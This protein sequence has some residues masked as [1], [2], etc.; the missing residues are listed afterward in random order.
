MWVPIAGF[1]TVSSAVCDRD[2]G[3]RHVERREPVPGISLGHGTR[4]PNRMTGDVHLGCWPKGQQRDEESSEDIRNTM[5][6]TTDSPTRDISWTE[7]SPHD[8]VVVGAGPAGSMAARAA[9]EGGASVLLIEEDWEIG[10]PLVCAE[11]VGKETL[12]QFVDVDPKWVAS[13]VEGAIFVSPSGRRVRVNYPDAGY[14]LERKVF[15]RDLAA[16]A[17]AAGARV[18][19]G[20]EAVGVSPGEN[21]LHRVEVRRGDEKGTIEA[22][23][24]IGADGF[25]SR[26]GRWAGLDTR[27]K[28]GEIHS[29]VQYLVA[30][31][32]VEEHY[33]EF[34]AGREIAPGGYAWVF[35][36]GRG[37]A[38]VGVGISPVTA[39]QSAL[40]Y[41]ERFLD[42]RFPGAMRLERMVGGVPAKPQERLVGNGLLLVGD[43]ARVADPISGA[44]IINALASGT[45]AGQIAA[46]ALR[47]G[48]V[49]GRRLAAYQDEWERT[50]G[51]DIRF[52]AR[53]RDVFLKL[54]DADFEAILDV[55]SKLFAKGDVRSIDPYQ[56][57][58]AIITSSPR[59][60]KIARHLLQ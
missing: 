37:T 8:C 29:C 1:A 41:L 55:G 11:G 9:A 43:A 46:A 40:E 57:V 17:A 24:V 36:K 23:L 27:L 31:A 47:E 12:A 54:T 26:V 58:R 22:R 13:R 59:F 51:K 20:L 15:D 21:G 48:D 42:Q 60:L 38:N 33:P 10:V 49:S 2:P 34:T 18:Q 16:L 4:S 53:I 7:A 14:I 28:P 25:R 5:P 50:I 45:M 6:Q 19:V 3:S 52:R 30:G 32:D 35:P 44:G 56:V 39:K